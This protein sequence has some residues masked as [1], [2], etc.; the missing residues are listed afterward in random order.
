M[1]ALA[2]ARA[3]AM[4]GKIEECHSTLDELWHRRRGMSQIVRLNLFGLLCATGAHQRAL[5]LGL[6]I[7]DETKTLSSPDLIKTHLWLTDVAFREGDIDTLKR[8]D[9]MAGEQNRARIMLDT[10]ETLPSG[11]RAAF[12]GLQQVTNRHLEGCY[13]YR[14]VEITP[15]D[16]GIDVTDTVYVPLERT[17][18]RALMARLDDAHDAYCDKMGLTLGAF[19]PPLVVHILPLSACDLRSADAAE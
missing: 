15:C 16:D 4:S 18:R 9:E 1:V 5:E 11:V 19:T 8:L 17:E 6:A 12:P 7:I 13:S 2:F 3:V 14:V 10:L